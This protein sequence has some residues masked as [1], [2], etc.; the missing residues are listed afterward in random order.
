[1]K[2]ITTI[3]VLILAG[4][5]S[6]FSGCNKPEKTEAYLFAYFIGNDRGEEAI[7]FAISEDGFSYRA[8]NNNQP[9]LDNQIISTTGGV[10]DP[11]ILRGN[12][13][14]TFYMVVTDLFVLEMGWKN[15]AMVLMKS[16][17]LINWESSV[18]NI[19]EAFPEK[20]GDVWRVWAPQTIYDEEAGK[21]MIY[22]SMKQNDDPD[23]IYYAYA[24]L[25]F[26]ALESEPKQLFF[27]PTNNSCI[28]ADII[29][30]DN[31][32]YLFH[33]SES[34]NPG[35]KLAISEKLTE[36]YEIIGNERVDKETSNVEGSGIFKLNNSDE[37]ILMYDV[38][39]LGRYQ[40]TKSSDLKNF[41]VIDEIISMNFKPRHGTVLPITLVEMKRLMDKW[42]TEEDPLIEA[43]S[44]L[45]RKQN[46]YVNG[47]KQI[48]RL[49]VKKGT[50]LTAFDPQFSAFTGIEISPSGPQDFSSGSVDYTININGKSEKVFQVL[51]TVDNN[52]V[53]DGFYADPEILYSEK[54]GKFYLYP[55]SDG[56]YHWGG[57]YFKV[58]SS[59]NLVDWKDE[60][61]MLDLKKDVSWANENA[62]APCIIEK[63]IDGVYK[64]FYYFTAKQKIGVAVADSPVG[65]FVDSGKALIDWLPD[66]VKGG[67]QIDPDVFT[68][69]K[70]GKSFLYWGN[71]YMAGAELNSDMISIK[72]ET[73]TIMTPDKTYREGA[74][75]IYRDGTYYFMWS[76]DDTRSPNYKV[77]YATS[78]TPLGKLTIPENNIVIQK[79][80]EKEILGTGHN[81][82]IQIPGK[83]EWY[84]VYHR[85]TFP[86][87]KT[88]GRFAGFHREVCIDKLEFDE[89]GN[90]IEV[91]PTLEGISR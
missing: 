9:V 59:E 29:E 28:D 91:K 25:D 7:R 88:M 18:V 49:P 42:V 85:F 90:I 38:Y 71:M 54:T 24:N 84:L 22:F 45:L 76:E 62:W 5:F 77:R 48:I 33:K 70:T 11:H 17:D 15:Y 65:P 75:V 63:K 41:T 2:R 51:A 16:N 69:P 68:D 13:G 74:Y 53:I 83:D 72:K 34:G 47:K 20:F 3:V 86:Q 56:Y 19:P 32:F 36:G 52:P 37:W 66:G 4:T 58:F 87:G 61:V 30:K 60:G 64:Y 57:S 35:I 40:F 80:L 39:S 8:L 6:I 21:Y 55:T 81:A 14:K 78:K 43:N 50:D 26:T 67:Q 89:N 46:V 23:I 79:D 44:E 27:N 73:I 10:R 1:M 31:K 12:D 82:A